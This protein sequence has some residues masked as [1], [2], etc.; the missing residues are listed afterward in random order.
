MTT[1]STDQKFQKL[2]DPVVRSQELGFI[3][4]NIGNC[5]QENGYLDWGKCFCIVL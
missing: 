1:V 3:T 4:R 2:P 5:K